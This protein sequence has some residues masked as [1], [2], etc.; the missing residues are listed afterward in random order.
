MVLQRVRHNWRLNNN[1]NT[2]KHTPSPEFKGLKL[3]I[4]L[5]M[6]SRCLPY[7]EA[8]TAAIELDASVIKAATVFASVL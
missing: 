7:P 1:N 5:K 3:A 8:S 2:H 6:N 4:F